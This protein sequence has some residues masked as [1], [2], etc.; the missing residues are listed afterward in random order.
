MDSPPLP[1]PHREPAAPA[2]A[3]SWPREGAL[4]LLLVLAPLFGWLSWRPMVH[5]DLWGHLAYGRWM[6][7]HGCL[8]AHEVFL[9]WDVEAPFV[10]TA[11]L[12]QWLGYLAYREG[13]IAAIQLLFAGLVA[14]TIA[15]LGLGLVRRT[16]R[17]LPALACAGTYAALEW[18]QW[19]VPD[20]VVCG[21]VRPQMAGA[22]CFVCLFTLLQMRKPRLGD[23]L[24]VGP[25]FAMWANLHGSFAIGWL[26]LACLVLG[27]AADLLRRTETVRSVRRDRLLRILLILLGAAV[28]GPLANPY[29][30]RLYADVLAFNRNP[31]LSILIE[32]QPLRIEQLQGLIAACVAF[33]LAVA[34]RTSP[35]RVQSAEPLLLASL[36]LA[37]LWTSRIIVWS[38]VPAAWF[39]ALHAHAAWRRSLRGRETRSIA[40]LAAHI[41]GLP[42]RPLAALTAV[43][44]I[45]AIVLSPW[46]L[47]SLGLVQPPLSSAVSPSTPLGAAQYLREHPPQGLVF[48]AFQ[49]GD[50]FLWDVPDID[51][52]ADSH[53]HLLPPRVWTDYQRIAGGANT[54]QRLLD[55]YHVELIAIDRKLQPY[56]IMQLQGSRKW[57]IV[58]EDARARIYARRTGPTDDPVR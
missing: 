53:V 42:R 34:Y 27:R 15:T 24:W 13:G 29:G 41:P 16:G 49:W 19:T 5:T 9:H 43:G 37:T 25:L 31:N 12:S 2:V 28:I 56:L 22:L 45:A 4:G 44:W 20:G 55:E 17:L 14:A 38:A 35:R 58:Y 7:T 26:L 52:F 39:L 8:P 51:V 36:G 54:Y 40:R 3:S 33:A 32:W 10:D 6:W 30:W 57:R 21:L 1:Q 46:G 18:R 47:Q 48:N 11:W 50:Y 23:A